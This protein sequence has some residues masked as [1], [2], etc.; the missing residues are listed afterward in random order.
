MYTFRGFSGRA[1]ADSGLWKRHPG[2]YRVE[3]CGG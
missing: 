1:L 2:A 3:S